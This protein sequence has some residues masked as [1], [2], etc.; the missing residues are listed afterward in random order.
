MIFV[1]Y[2]AAGT[3]SDTGLGPICNSCPLHF[4]QPNVLAKKCLECPDNQ[5]TQ[6]EGSTALTDC[7]DGGMTYRKIRF[8]INVT[9]ERK[10]KI[11]S[12]IVLG[13]Q[14]LLTV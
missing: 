13:M 6:K 12:Q 11:Q 10:I 5:I 8:S 4:Y 14:V 7:I 9:Y 2:C 3:W 1:A